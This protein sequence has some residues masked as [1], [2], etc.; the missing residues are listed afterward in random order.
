MQ[1]AHPIAASADAAP[2]RKLC[3]DC[4]LSR[5]AEPKRCGQACQ[6][7]QP[8]YPGLERRE[9][10]DL[11]RARATSAMRSPRGPPLPPLFS[12]PA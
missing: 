11:V 12:I 4:G 5:T 9:P 1:Q 7:I 3:T 8:D 10:V 2:A 6:F